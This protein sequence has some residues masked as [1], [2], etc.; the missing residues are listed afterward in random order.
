M[1]QQVVRWHLP[2]MEEEKISKDVVLASIG[3]FLGDTLYVQFKGKN[4]SLSAGA[5]SRI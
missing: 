5:Q 2:P 3:T 4:I 1:S